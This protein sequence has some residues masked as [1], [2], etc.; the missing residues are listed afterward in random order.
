MT[1]LRLGLVAVL[2]AA[3]TMVFGWWCVAVIGLLY[4]IARGTGRSLGLEA[5]AG[6]ALGWTALLAWSAP[7]GPLWQVAVA[8]G[9]VFGLPGWAFLAVTLVFAGLLAASA[10]LVGQ[11]VGRA[12]PLLLAVTACSIATEPHSVGINFTAVW[13]QFDSLTTS[14]TV[15]YAGAGPLLGGRTCG[16]TR[17]SEIHCWAHLSPQPR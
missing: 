3:G 15:S 8:V 16:L 1:A 4:G 13:D 6:A 10:A 17:E 7:P 12:V 9:G 14:E 2:A 5:G 11:S